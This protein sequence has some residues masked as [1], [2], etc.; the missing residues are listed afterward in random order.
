ML[1]ILLSALVECGSGLGFMVV[2]AMWNDQG[3]ARR[4][5]K[6]EMAEP[7]V[8]LSPETKP[9]E[10]AS[11]LLSPEHQSG[12]AWTSPCAR[13]I[14]LTDLWSLQSEFYLQYDTAKESTPN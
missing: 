13:C 6:N 1:T 10:R 2:L 7:L 3:T 4:P 12:Y 11:L 5:I 14:S 9:I 8:A